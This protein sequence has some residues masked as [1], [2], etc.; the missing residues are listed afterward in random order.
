MRKFKLY[1][2]SIQTGQ[3]SM[4]T[5]QTGRISML[6]LACYTVVKTACV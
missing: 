4:L 2:S 3:I 1:L 6:T 5:L